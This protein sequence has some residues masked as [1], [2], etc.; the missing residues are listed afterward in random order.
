MLPHFMAARLY[1]SF[2]DLP[3]SLGE[4]WRSRREFSIGS[5]L[6]GITGTYL[7]SPPVLISIC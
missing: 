5:H 6:L 3:E 7:T 1:L 2:S 4:A